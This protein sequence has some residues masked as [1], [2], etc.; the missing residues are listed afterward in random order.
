MIKPL[1]G[2]TKTLSLL[3]S[4]LLLHACGFHL[5]GTY[6]L[7]T[8]LSA[9]SVSVPKEATALKQKLYR[10]L[11]QNHVHLETSGYRL[12]ITQETINSQSTIFDPRSQVMNTHVIYTLNYYIASPDGK[13]RIDPRPLMEQNDYQSSPG[14]ISGGNEENLMI[15][16]DM[17]QEAVLQL[18][19]RLQGVKADQFHK[20][21]GPDTQGS[22]S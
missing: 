5:R 11:E 2:A 6:Q 16:D 10:V 18:L 20:I 12:V 9:L 17:R 8:F 7:P 4:S 22:A 13:K 21:Q 3:I 19:N 1:R 14:A 15:I